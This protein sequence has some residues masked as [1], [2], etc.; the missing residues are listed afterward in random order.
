MDDWGGQSERKRR[1]GR[2]LRASVTK[3][4]QTQ[5]FGKETEIRLWSKWL[6][7]FLWHATD[8]GKAA[9][10]RFTQPP[11]TPTRRLTEPPPPPLIQP[12]PRTGPLRFTRPALASGAEEIKTPHRLRPRS[13]HPTIS[14]GSA[15]IAVDPEIH[16][17]LPSSFQWMIHYS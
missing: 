5:N 16:F 4:I 14:R 6:I 10:Q 7:S 9:Y 1:N 11:P 13:P 3:G 2:S 15:E 8:S 12:P 17:R